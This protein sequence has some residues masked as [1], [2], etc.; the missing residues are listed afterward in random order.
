MISS[1]RSSRR[2]ASIIRSSPSSSSGNSPSSS[3]RALDPVEFGGDLGRIFG[4]LRLDA[5]VVREEAVIGIEHRFGPGPVGAQFGG[6]LFELLDRE[7]VDERRIVHEAVVLAAEQIA[8]DPAAGGLIGLDAD[9]QAE[10]GIERDRAAG[11]QTPAPDA[12]RRN[13]GP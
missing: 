4:R 8:G 12:A 7:A 9:K 6:F 5:A 11:Q 10:I 13:A 1:R 2:A 3:S